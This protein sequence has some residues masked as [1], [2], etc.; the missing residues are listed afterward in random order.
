MFSLARQNSCIKPLYVWVGIVV[1]PR[2]G[3]YMPIMSARSASNS[4]NKLIAE[5]KDKMYARVFADE[6]EFGRL[7]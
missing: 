5:R 7:K 6:V 1:N 2:Q 3:R 4:Q